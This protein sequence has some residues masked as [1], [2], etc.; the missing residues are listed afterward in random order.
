MMAL[1]PT[2]TKTRV[3]MAKRRAAREIIFD[4]LTFLCES[5]FVLFDFG[6]DDEKT[7]KYVWFGKR[8]KTTFL[9]LANSQINTLKERKSKFFKKKKTE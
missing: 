2:T 7:L 9:K 6:N 8:D 3:M 4:Y 1:V 5:S